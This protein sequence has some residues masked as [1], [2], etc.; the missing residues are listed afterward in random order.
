MILRNNNIQ[1][2]NM[3]ILTLHNLQR[4]LIS[5]I[6]INSLESLILQIQRLL[7]IQLHIFLQLHYFILQ[8]RIMHRI[9]LKQLITLLLHLLILLTIN[10]LL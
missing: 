6:Q 1:L 5:Q 10:L 9:L 8:N 2:L 4:L 7:I 3:L